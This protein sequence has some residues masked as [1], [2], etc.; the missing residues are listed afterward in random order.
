MSVSVHSIFHFE[1]CVLPI[2]T[3]Y[4]AHPDSLNLPN[5]PYH[6][7][8]LI[9]IKRTFSM[10]MSVVFGACFED[11]QCLLLQLA[12]FKFC[13]HS[14]IILKS[15]DE[16]QPIFLNQLV[17]PHFLVFGKNFLFICISL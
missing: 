2:K 9:Q 1:Y 7:H 4:Y 15:H 11:R 12:V 17:R 5:L 3:F 10:L 16:I 14:F 8:R 13:S 6:I